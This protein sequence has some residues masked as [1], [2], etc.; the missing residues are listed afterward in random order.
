MRRAISFLLLALV[1]VAAGAGAAVGATQ[2]S[3]GAP[4]SQAVT[5]TLAAPNYTEVLSEKTPQGNQVAHLVFQAPDRLGGYVQSGS[6]RTYIAVIG[7]NEYQS[8]TV[9]ASHGPSHL[10][11]YS[12]P[13]QGAIAVDPAHT[14]LPFYSKG[15]NL[16][17][18]GSTTTMTLSQGGQSDKLT[19]VVDGSYVS[20]FAAV[21]PTGNLSLA[22]S[23]VGTS[24]PVVL[25][26]KSKIV[27]APA[28]ASP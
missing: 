24:P 13:S 16:Q 3:S 4:L 27:A 25:P 17:K 11:I 21:T 23:D 19:F 26:A 15:T 5:N 20:D 12:Q 14:Y 8:V 1:L 28:S 10:T 18:S 9:S 7:T 22:I 2:A 6:R